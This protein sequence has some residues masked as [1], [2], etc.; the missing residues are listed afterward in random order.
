MNELSLY[1]R[2]LALAEEAHLIGCAPIAD[3]LRETASYLNSSCE[4]NQEKL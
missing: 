4:L 1:Y 3:D 2:L